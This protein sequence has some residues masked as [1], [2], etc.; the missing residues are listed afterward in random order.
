MQEGLLHESQISGD[1]G[2]AGTGVRR[3]HGRCQKTRAGWLGKEMVG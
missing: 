1:Q 2:S 3:A